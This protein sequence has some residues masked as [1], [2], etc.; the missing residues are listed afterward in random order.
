MGADRLNMNSKAEFRSAQSANPCIRR[1]KTHL[2][3]L[4]ILFIVAFGM[5]VY[6]IHEPP[7]DFHPTRQYRSAIVAR[8]YYYETLQSIPDWEKK[9]A[10]LNKAELG[11]IEPPIMELLALLGYRIAGAELLWIPRVLSVLFWLGGGICLYALAQ[12]LVSSGA[13]VCSAAFYL[14]LPFG[15][16]ASRSFQPD[17]LMV[18]AFLS[19]IWAISRYQIQPSGSRLAIATVLSALAI[20]IKPV[21][22]F[23][24]LSAFILANISRRGIRK[25]AT[26]PGL[27]VFGIASLLPAAAFY[28]Y[29][30]FIS[31]FLR[32]NINVSF[33]PRLYLSPTYWSGWLKQI[34]DTVGNIALVAALLGVFLFR[35]GVPKALVAGLWVGYAVFGL[36]FNYHVHTHDYY[37]MQFIPIVA[38]SLTPIAAL[39]LSGLA[40]ARRPRFRRLALS[41]VIL[42]AALLYIRKVEWRLRGQ[43]A[44]K[45]AI[46][47][48][49]GAITQ[50]SLGTIFLASEYGKTLEYYGGIYGHWWPNRVDLRLEKLLGKEALTVPKRLDSLIRR[51]SPDYFI[52]TSIKEYEAQPELQRYMAKT[53]PIVKQTRDYY[54]FDLRKRSSSDYIPLP[55]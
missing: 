18:F 20:F 1:S 26:D 28:S 42:F 54:I 43:D 51:Y 50:H 55:R 25:T 38:L 10:A 33:I 23:A 14:F 45:A 41:G 19:S 11:I 2:I 37:Q 24:I 53:F 4:G 17:P 36:V 22:L 47:Q 8:G 6:R 52:V 32:S 31:G 40:G 48:E 39:A 12:D 15:I 27:L 16:P 21:C 34:D 29:G 13:A 3:T 7:Y 30:I 5:R 46:A 44:R 35:E 49:I 9:V